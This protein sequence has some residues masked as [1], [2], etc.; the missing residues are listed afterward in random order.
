M[1][2]DTMITATNERLFQRYPQG[3]DIPDISRA[4]L[5]TQPSLAMPPTEGKRL[6]AESGVSSSPEHWATFLHRR[7]TH[8]GSESVLRSCANRQT[9]PLPV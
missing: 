8:D 6:A 3:A 4:K 1:N 5:D 7:P 2:H 9:P